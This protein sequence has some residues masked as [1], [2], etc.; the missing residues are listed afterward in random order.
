MKRILLQITAAL[1]A[2]S[3][4]AQII[5]AGDE[6]VTEAGNLALTTVKMNVHDGILHAGA[7]YGG[8]WTRDISINIWNGVSFIDP[9]TAETSLWAVTEKNGKNIGHQYWD[10]IIWVRGAYTHYLVSHD[11]Q[12]LKRAYTCGA[13]TMA[14]LEK[15]VFDSRYGL[16]MGPSVFNDGIAGYDIPIYIPARDSDSHVF[17][18]DTKRIKC[19]STNVIYYIAYQDLNAM[20]RILY[21]RENKEFLQKAAALKARIREVFYKPE[22][23]RFIYLIDQ[24]GTPHDY[25]EALGVAY[26]VL[27]GIV[28]RQEGYRVTCKTEKSAFGIPSVV[29]HFPRFSDE[30]PG[31][32]N[33]LIWPFVSSFYACA[34]LSVGNT[35]DFD[36]EFYS[37]ATLALDRDKGNRNFYEIFNP[38]SGKPDGGWQSGWHW[39]SCRH[40]TWSATGYVAILLYGVAGIELTSDGICFA[41][42]MPESLGTLNIKG[43]KYAGMDLNISLSGEGSR[44]RAFRING[45]KSN[46][47]C[48]P[49]N[50]TGVQT[51]EIELG[52]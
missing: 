15:T 26:A 33:R 22:E 1:W 47:Y 46:N 31:R 21:G 39:D 4:P 20:H 38:D 43:L 48:L 29:P 50:L 27:G 16:F 23:D 19:L 37:M 2:C 5:E 51:V 6:R 45:K 12:F 36:K 52:D 3:L 7:D 35:A 17:D 44:V 13:N 28:D 25:Q 49:V 18:H 11:S 8:E 14:Q 34:A 40:Q 9:K 10:K 41:P 24:N 32:H 42:Y 30:K